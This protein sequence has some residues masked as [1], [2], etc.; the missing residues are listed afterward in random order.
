MPWIFCYNASWFC[1][2][3]V[4]YRIRNYAFNYYERKLELRIASTKGKDYYLSLGI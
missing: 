1:I 2:C 4:G 3:S